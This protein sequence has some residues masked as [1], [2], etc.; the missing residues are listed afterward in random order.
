MGYTTDFS[1]HF[2]V[3]PTVAPEHA[4]YINKFNETRRMKRD[5]SKALVLPDPIRD[6][7]DLPIGLEGS[8]FVGG[9]GFAG[10]ENDV[11]ILNHS[12]PPEGQPGLWCQWRISEDRNRLEWDGE[13]KFYNYV[14]WLQYL[15]DHFFSKWGYTLNGTVYW[16]GEDSNDIGQIVV[17]DNKVESTESY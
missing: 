6:A 13:E 2:N 1:G 12:S 10:Q 7:T 11:S 5:S 8:Y 3:T 17:I 4:A 14:E 15:I 9:I 16:N